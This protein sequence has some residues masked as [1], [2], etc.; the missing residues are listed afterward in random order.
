[1]GLFTFRI[2]I[3]FVAFT[4]IVARWLRNYKRT[5]GFRLYLHWIEEII[6][7]LISGWYMW[8]ILDCQCWIYHRMLVNIPSID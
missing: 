7:C 8:K 4:F 2:P 6:Y 1:M 5:V 3:K